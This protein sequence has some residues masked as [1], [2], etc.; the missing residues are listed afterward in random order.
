MGSRRPQVYEIEFE[1][2]GQRREAYH[3]WIEAD[4]IQWIAHDAVAG[5]EVYHNER[6]PDPELK[7]VFEFE[8]LGEWERFV[9]SDE[10]DR[11]TDRLE[12]FTDGLNATLWN[13]DSLTLSWTGDTRPDGGRDPSRRSGV[14]RPETR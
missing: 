7:F 6:G 8:S 12:T 1:V 9:D 5:F 13:R 10:H 11:A 3:A 4:A 2:P 14:H